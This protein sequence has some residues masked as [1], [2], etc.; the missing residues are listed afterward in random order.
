MAT[1]SETRRRTGNLGWATDNGPVS[2]KL[3]RAAMEVKAVAQR[4]GSQDG[5]TLVRLANIVMGE[6]PRIET[7]ERDLVPAETN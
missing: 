1:T 5:E 4:V 6:C 3:L 7:M 2:R